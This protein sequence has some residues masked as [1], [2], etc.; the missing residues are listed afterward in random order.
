MLRIQP[1]PEQAPELWSILG[2]LLTSL[3]E[4]CCFTRAFLF[5]L[6]LSVLLEPFVVLLNPLYFTGPLLLYRILAV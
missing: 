1:E 3:L 6:I 5:Y 2:T 4:P